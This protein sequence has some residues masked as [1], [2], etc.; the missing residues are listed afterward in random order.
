MAITTSTEGASAPTSLRLD[1]GH[2]QNWQTDAV[3]VAVLN[4]ASTVHERIAYCWG[5]A[6]DLLELSELLADSNDDTVVRVVSR[7]A[8]HLHPLVAVLTN[9]GDSTRPMLIAQRKSEGQ[10]P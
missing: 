4:E 7:Y 3:A 6:V 1:H 9:L 10:Q 5:L 8:N 2:N